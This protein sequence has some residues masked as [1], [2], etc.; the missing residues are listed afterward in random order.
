MAVGEM[1]TP[2]RES[3]HEDHA[4]THDYENGASTSERWERNGRGL[5]E[6]LNLEEAYKKV[7]NEG[8]SVRTFDIETEIKRA[9]NNRYQK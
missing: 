6:G 3:R 1:C 8:K 5:K 2:T 4:T 7:A 9:L